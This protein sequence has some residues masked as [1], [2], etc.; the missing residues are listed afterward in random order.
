MKWKVAALAVAFLAAPAFA[1]A[2]E[3]PA[4]CR[5]DV[6]ERL[7][8]LRGA[9]DDQIRGLEIW[10]YSWGSIYT[11]AAATQAI[12]T[13]QLKPDDPAR[14]DL[15][16]GAVSAGVGSLTFW[17]APLRFTLPL[18]NVRKDWDNPDRCALLARA[19]AVRTKVASEQRLGKSWIA[20]AG[21]VLVNVG[22]SLIL[23]LGYNH[24][25]AALISGLVGTAIGELNL[26]TQPAKLDRV[27]EGPQLRLVPLVTT[28][29]GG[30]GLFVVF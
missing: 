4:G 2:E 14:T 23:G 25:Q 10:S 8:V 19:E 6:E 16:V 7:E 24:W 1:A 17:V 3:A 30:A 20:H 21:N 12:V 5:E 22:I 28:Q 15:I 9:F 18:K 13:T 11:A 29:G 26:F 27:E